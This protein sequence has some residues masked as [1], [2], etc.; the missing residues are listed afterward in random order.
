M[1]IENYFG[2]PEKPGAQYTK[3]DGTRVYN[4]G[5]QTDKIDGEELLPWNGRWLQNPYWSAYQ[6]ENSDKKN[7][8][9][10][11][12]E[13]SPHGKTTKENAHPHSD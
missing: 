12:Y 5:A 4:P 13:W 9:T 3:P 10:R 7:K 8:D 1:D 2:D 11:S 6:Y